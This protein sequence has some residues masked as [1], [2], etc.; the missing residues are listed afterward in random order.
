MSKKKLPNNPF[1]EE[2][3]MKPLITYK[4][5]EDRNGKLKQ[6]ARTA[7]NFWNHFVTPA[8]SIVIR[9]GLFSDD[10]DTIAEAYKPYT[11]KRVK[12]GRI[13]FNTVYLGQ[14][15]PYRVAG[16]I[17]HEIGHTLGF[18]WHPWDEMF[19]ADSGKFL[20]GYVAK[21]PALAAMRVET[22]GDE[23]TALAHW[24][25]ARFRTELM[26]GWKDSAEHVLPVTIGI[27]ALLGHKVKHEIGRKTNLSTLLKE[28][29][30]T[31]FKQKAE[32]KKLDLDL[33]Q[34][35]DLW[36]RVYRTDDE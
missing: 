14:F 31:V 36:E 22:H 29:K 9:L 23:G 12:Y 3:E 6:S 34:Y 25:E 1:K 7:C 10:S 19:D 17:V 35:T 33:L 16:T 2:A 15:T 26:T 4:I 8:T 20:P 11:A 21:L 30:A 18:G 24:D 28:H 27:M 5:S 32:A 13:N